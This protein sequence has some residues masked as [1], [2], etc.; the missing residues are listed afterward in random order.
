[1]RAMWS[2]CMTRRPSASPSP[3]ASGKL[4]L[5]GGATSERN[6]QCAH[7]RGLELLQGYLSLWRLTSSHMR[8]SSLHFGGADLSIIAPS[9]DPHTAKNQ[10]SEPRPDGQPLG[11]DRACSTAAVHSGGPLGAVLGGAGP[12]STDDRV[13]VQVS[14]WDHLKDMQGV[15]EGFAGKSTRQG[16]CDSPSWARR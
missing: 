3:C 13:V 5:F 14:R 4:G 6:E 2:S 7:G 12:I 1:M 16:D 8:V 10:P 15:L 9:I 11:E